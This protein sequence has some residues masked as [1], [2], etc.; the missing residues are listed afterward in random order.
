MKQTTAANLSL[1]LVVMA[2]A[3]LACSAGAAMVDPG[4]TVDPSRFFGDQ[5]RTAVLWSNAGL[6]LLLS[7][8]WLAGH[9]YT[10]ARVRSVLALLL[11]IGAVCWLYWLH[12]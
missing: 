11:C 5:Q 7:G 12:R 1:V 2:W 9:A 10:A 6:L 8:T 3:A 4:P